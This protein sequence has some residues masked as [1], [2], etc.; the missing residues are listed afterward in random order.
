MATAKAR[1]RMRRAN[2]AWWGFTKSQTHPFDY[3]YVTLHEPLAPASGCGK[4][5]TRKMA[6]VKWHDKYSTGYLSK[7]K[8]VY[9]IKIASN[10]YDWWLGRHFGKHEGQAP[11]LHGARIM[12][13]M[14]VK[15]IRRE[16]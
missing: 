11:T 12:A 14:Q 1:A 10:A 16:G 9:T 5:A 8:R 13:A 15:R 3:W 6:R 7:G 4:R 2:E